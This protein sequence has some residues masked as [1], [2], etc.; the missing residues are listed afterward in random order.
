MYQTEPS[1][2]I[3]ERLRAFAGRGGEYRDEPRAPHQEPDRLRQADGLSGTV[4]KDLKN[5]KDE[6]DTL[7]ATLK[8]KA[9]SGQQAAAQ[10]ALDKIDADLQGGIN[11][12]S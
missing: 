7:G 11:Y 1:G 10:A 2:E 12:F 8:S 5:I 4:L 9:P 6:T 3:D